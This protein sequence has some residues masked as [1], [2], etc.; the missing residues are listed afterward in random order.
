M[1]GR[2]FYTKLLKETG[3]YTKRGKKK[4]VDM[5]H[6]DNDTKSTIFSRL[7]PIKFEHLKPISAYSRF[8]TCDQQNASLHQSSN[9]FINL[10]IEV[11]NNCQKKRK[12]DSSPDDCY[13][14]PAKKDFSP[15]ALSPDLGCFMD[16]SSP[17][18]KQDCV[19]PLATSMPALLNKTQ[20]IRSEEEQSS[21]SEPHW[22]M[23]LNAT[24]FDLDVDD[25]LCLNPLSTY[26][27]G[28]F[29]DNVQRCTSPNSDTFQNKPALAPNVAHK[30][31]LGR[32]DG[33]V[34]EE[35]EE[36]KEEMHLNVKDVEEDKG[37]FSMSYL[38]DHK[39]GVDSPQ[40]P[41]VTCS[42]LR[43]GEDE[44]QPESAPE[45]GCHKQAVLPGQDFSFTVL[46]SGP[47]VRGPLVKPA[48]SLFEPLEGDVEEMWNIGSPLFESSV[49]NNVTVKLSADSEQ[50]RQVSEEVR[51]EVMEAVDKCQAT[52]GR[53]ESTL[54]TSYETTLPL[55]VQVKSVV[56]AL[57]HH[58]ASSEPAAPLLPYQGPNCVRGGVMEAVDKCQATVGGEESTLDTS[59]ETTLPLQ[60]QVKSVVVALGQH[61]ASSEPAAPL[62][63][64]QGPNC[65][66]NAWTERP[67]IADRGVILE[68]DKQL[69]LQMVTRHMNENQ[70]GNKDVMTELLN[71]M[72][73]VA[74]QA[75]GTKANQWQHPS[76]L[77]RRNYQR[78]FGNTT[79]T[80][81]LQEW[82]AK[83]LATYKRFAQLP[84]IFKRSPYD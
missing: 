18:T 77:T 34:K 52:V 56:V 76:D 71:L 60:V 75:Q 73:H 37:Y 11:V 41:P 14:T 9:P 64:Y 43:R 67:V 17:P 47:V 5:A 13:E 32:G 27:T 66:S 65:V 39:I 53:E 36:P 49:C 55:Q 6:T 29:S 79:P 63:P 22:K 51:G 59:Y 16:F 69:Y 35:Q 84:K 83:N 58:A 2:R 45:P 30:T 7:K 1:S 26:A 20:A 68:R 8:I 74:D 31:E 23:H 3:L 81:S 50:S 21:S 44:R 25:I 15:Q 46:D 19:S 62:L 48:D 61:P 57:G 42:P 54:D 40:L 24:P 10:K 70:G 4:V 80:M 33:Q 82:Q 12:L 72:T 28:A 38:K 78:R